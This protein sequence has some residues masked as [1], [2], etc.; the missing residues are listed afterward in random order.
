[1]EKH[2]Y[3]NTD[4]LSMKYP[5]TLITATE[6]NPILRL[7][8]E[9]LWDEF[10]KNK[11]IDELENIKSMY[12]N[13][14][15]KLIG[16]KKT[17]DNNKKKTKSQKPKIPIPFYGIVQNNWCCGIKKNHGLY[18]QCCKPRP[19]DGD[20]CKVCSRQA[21]NNADGKPNCGD[22]RERAQ[23]WTNELKY[24][25]PGMKREVPYANVM[26]KLNITINEAQEAV[27]SL[28][29]Q[30]I[31]EC[32]LIEKKVRRGRPKTKVAVEDSDDEQP[33]RKRGRPKK[34]V[35]VEMT[36]EELIAQFMANA[37]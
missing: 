2:T 33:K 22:I 28:G 26:S 29:W 1:M 8:A 30:P 5:N 15:K 21:Q 10:I 18:T 7:F 34:E 17:V 24:R 12:W 11:D 32:H 4:N 25:P 14:V 6:L 36:D 31:P 27:E 37:M 13:S 3:M 23:Q 20:Y 9:K 16:E 35:K 19:A